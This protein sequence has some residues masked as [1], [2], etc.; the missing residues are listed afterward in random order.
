MK[1]IGSHIRHNAIQKSAG[2]PAE[3]MSL[4][5]AASLTENR[6]LLGREFGSPPPWVRMLCA[7]HSEFWTFLFS[8]TWYRFFRCN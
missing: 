2:F 6:H 8:E 4:L 3:R 5:G 7:G 1:A